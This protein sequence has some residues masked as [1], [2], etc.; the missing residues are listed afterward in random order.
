MS[1]PPK[2]NARNGLKKSKRPL[3]FSFK[4][5]CPE[6][7]GGERDPGSGDK[8]QTFSI[9]HVG[10]FPLT[11]CRAHDSSNR[12]SVTSFNRVNFSFLFQSFSAK[13]NYNSFLVT[14]CAVFILVT[15]Q[16]PSLAMP[17]IH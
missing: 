1:Q 15:Q 3:E 14:I 5:G 16:I 6:P 10:G 9:D 17:F 8:I 7:T 12:L 2:T 4:S 13:N 11:S